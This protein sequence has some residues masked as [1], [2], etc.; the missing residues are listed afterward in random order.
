MNSYSVSVSGINRQPVTAATIDDALAL[1]VA[2]I[3]QE[4]ATSGPQW[5]GVYVQAS[6]GQ[7]REARAKNQNPAPRSRMGR[8][9]WNH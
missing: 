4:P 2:S 9:V 3:A 6:D 7:Y 1:V 8:R 5:V